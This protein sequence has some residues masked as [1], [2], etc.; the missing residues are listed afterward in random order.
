MYSLN[1]SRYFC[2]HILLDLR[3]ELLI[4]D[5]LLGEYRNFFLP[6]DSTD[7]LLSILSLVMLFSLRTTECG[8]NFCTNL[9]Y[10]LYL[11]QYPVISK[12]NIYSGTEQK[13]QKITWKTKFDSY[14]LSCC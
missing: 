9:S 4:T 3:T 12:E 13:F 14:I 1:F 6:L 8:N 5:V 2:T 10:L 11:C 7:T